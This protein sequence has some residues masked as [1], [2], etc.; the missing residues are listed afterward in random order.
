MKGGSIMKI[1]NRILEATINNTYAYENLFLTT[2]RGSQTYV[3]I[4]EA[5]LRLGTTPADR[6]I[7]Y[8]ENQLLNPVK[9]GH[10]K[11]GYHF[12]VSDE[13]VVQFIYTKFRTA[14]AGCFDGNSSIAIQRV[15]NCNVDFAK[16]IYNQAKLAATLMVKFGMPLN[17]IVPRSYWETTRSDSPTRLNALPPTEANIKEH[18]DKV[19]HI[20]G[21]MTWLEFLDNVQFCYNVD[22][23]FDINEIL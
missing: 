1:Q 11:L 23:I 9:D 21:N 8:Y 22:D 15:V 17:H 12:M 10:E 4:H 14:H 2:E 3:T 6:T 7:E 18:P 13:E 5:S 19:C 20:P 16:A